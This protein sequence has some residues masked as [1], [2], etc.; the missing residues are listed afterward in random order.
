[1]HFMLEEFG[2]CFIAKEESSLTSATILT[3]RPTLNNGIR[4]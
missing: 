2:F 4:L 1:M 3:I